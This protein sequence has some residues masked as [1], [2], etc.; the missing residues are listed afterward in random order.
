MRPSFAI[1]LILVAL[2]TGCGD[3]KG[4]SNPLPVAPDEIRLTSAAFD[5]NQPIPR[6]FTCDGDNL[7]PPLEWSNVPKG[8]QSFALLMEDR[9][10][11]GGNFVHWTVFG[12]DADT[13]SLAA[14]QLP[15]G[16]M[17]GENSF[18]DVS[19]AGPC[20][21]KGDDPHHY[22]LTIYALKRALPLDQGAKPG[23]VRSAI[24]NAAIARGQLTGTYARA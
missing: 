10:A 24:A 23:E 21:P 8:T 11:P 5:Q 4:M 3:G 6:Q 14:E 20:P 13:D 22:V 19:Y 1:A 18:G 2:L 15:E 7:P 16:V 12:I 17:R 9:D